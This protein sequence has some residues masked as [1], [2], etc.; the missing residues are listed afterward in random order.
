MISINELT[1]PAETATSLTLPFE[2]R[3]KSRLRVTLDNG[4][5]AGLFLPRGTLLRGGDYLLAEDGRII[6]VKAAT[7]STSTAYSNDPFTLM[8]A[9][10][11]LGN[12]HIPVEIGVNFVRYQHDHVLDDMVASFGLDVK[13]EMAPFEP[14]SGAYHSHG[15]HHHSH[16]H[17]RS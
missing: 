10:Y 15:S 12:R 17:D 2:L 13:H 8:R 14:E 7:E 16:D 4:E 1:S 5:E 3:Q 11:H 6:L 9:C